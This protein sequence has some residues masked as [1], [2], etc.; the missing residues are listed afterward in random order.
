MTDIQTIFHLCRWF[1]TTPKGW[2]SP[3]I[4]HFVDRTKNCASSDLA[5]KIHNPDVIQII[6]RRKVVIRRPK[7]VFNP[8]RGPIS[9]HICFGPSQV[10]RLLEN[11]FL[12]YQDC[13][14]FD[15]KNDGTVCFGLSAEIH[16]IQ[17]NTDYQTTDYPTTRVSRHHFV[18]PLWC[19]IIPVPLS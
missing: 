2:K 10:P 12:L 16:K 1:D 19:R 17:C 18:G 3:I 4:L 11:T 8:Y 14:F 6:F 9:P 5:S 7:T 13:V 15:N